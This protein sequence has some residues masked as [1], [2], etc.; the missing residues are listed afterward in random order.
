LRLYRQ[1]AALGFSD[2]HIRIGELLEYGKGTKA[3]PNDA[4]VSYQKR[5][6]RAIS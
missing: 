6:R 3:N 5:P 4:L 2:A 1:S